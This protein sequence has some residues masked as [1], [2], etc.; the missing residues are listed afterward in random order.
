LRPVA[1]DAGVAEQPRDVVRAE[2][3]HDGGVEPAERSTEIVAFPQDCQP[4]QPGLERLQTQPLEHGGV[5]TD[6]T[7]PLVIVVREVI[8]AAQGP[9]TT[10]LAIRP[11]DCSRSPHDGGGSS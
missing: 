1:H 7:A 2:A 10:E 8:L 4:G 5:V 11:G 6:W 3:R 9:W